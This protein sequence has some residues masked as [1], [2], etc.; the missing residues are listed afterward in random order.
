LRSR[1]Q[2]GTLGTATAHNKN[3]GAGQKTAKKTMTGALEETQSTTSLEFKTVTAS[4]RQEKVHERCE[5][6]R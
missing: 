3:E 4:I 6:E 2:V 1:N 5:T